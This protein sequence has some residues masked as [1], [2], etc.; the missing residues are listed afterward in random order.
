MKLV[1]SWHV[2]VLS[3]VPVLLLA[4]STSLA[5]QTIRS[6]SIAGTVTDESGGV[7]PGATITLTSPALQVPEVVTVSDGR[8]QYQF[9]D[10]PVGQFRVAVELQGFSPLLRERII[11]NAG[12]NARVDVV[13][14]VAAQEAAI[15]VTAESPVVG[16]IST[17]GITTVTR[18]VLQTLPTASNYIDT[19]VLVPGAS[20]PG[21]PMDGEIGYR[22]HTG[23]FSSYGLTDQTSLVIEGIEM[24]INERPDF[25]TIEEVTTRTYGNTA[26]VSFPGAQTEI[27]VRSG[28]NDFSGRY[29]ARGMNRDYLGWTNVDDRLRRQRVTEPDGPTY[30][31]NLTGDLGGRIVRDKLWFYVAHNEVHNL[32]TVPGYSKDPGPDGIYQTSDD[33]SGAPTGRNRNQTIKLS[34]QVTPKHKL[35]GFH[36]RGTE[37]EFQQGA[38]R[39]V[40]FESTAHIV[41]S[42]RQKKL[43]WQGTLSE[44]LFATLTNGREGVV[45]DHV[46]PSGYCE[47]D[48]QSPRPRDGLRDRHELAQQCEPY[49]NPQSP[50]IEW[51]PVLLSGGLVPPDSSRL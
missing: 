29:T 11:L 40:P 50:P 26:E 32:R 25:D 15:T 27:I 14:T 51:E 7:L 9:L 42:P 36:T 44:Q 37:V 21:P 3:V 5:G 35:I 13:M 49:E 16:A 6:G 45:R 39:L 2:R 28:G 4:F 20:F 24:V 23:R 22:G 47:E 8:G 10:L 34:Y 41:H 46:Q 31:W 48:T 17:R 38:S 19:L 33:T 30:Y 1:P 18:E 12:F 43:E